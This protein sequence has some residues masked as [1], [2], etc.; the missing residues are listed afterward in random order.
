MS[1]RQQN[2]LSSKDNFYPFIFFFAYLSRHFCHA[3]GSFN[4][5]FMMSHFAYTLQS[6]NKTTNTWQREMY[7]NYATLLNKFK[8]FRD[9]KR[10]I[11]YVTLANK[12][13]TYYYGFLLETF[14]FF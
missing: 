10:F 6:A 9:D 13:S 12:F 14:R 1:F 3:I 2:S 5:F 11:S 8:S 4:D 7:I